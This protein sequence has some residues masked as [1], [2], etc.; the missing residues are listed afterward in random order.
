LTGRTSL[1]RIDTGEPGSDRPDVSSDDAHGIDRSFGRAVPPGTV[2]GQE[3]PA[4][5]ER[6]AHPIPRFTAPSHRM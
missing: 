5:T 4:A 2:P 1:A 3:R 6:L